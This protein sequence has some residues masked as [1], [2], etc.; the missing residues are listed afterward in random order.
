MTDEAEL[1]GPEVWGVT[2]P[3]AP[4]RDP[5]RTTTGAVVKVTDTAPRDDELRVRILGLLD[6]IDRHVGVVDAELAAIRV[7]LE[8]ASRA[9]FE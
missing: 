3:D 4:A 8:D 1:W 9:A 5:D 6:E 2:P 7:L